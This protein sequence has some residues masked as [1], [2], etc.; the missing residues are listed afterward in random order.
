MAD[1]EKVCWLARVGK[2]VEP[3]GSREP[4]SFDD[5]R[6]VIVPAS[7]FLRAVPKFFPSGLNRIPFSPKILARQNR[8][9][10]SRRFGPAES[11]GCKLRD[12]RFGNISIN[13]ANV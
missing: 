1:T 5:S 3:V 6:E 13:V 7:R 8:G 10:K 9:E 11:S 4:S 2:R 12:S